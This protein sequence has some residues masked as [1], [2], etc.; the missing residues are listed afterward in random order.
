[1]TTSTHP[2]RRAALAWAG[3]TAGALAALC[4]L[5]GCA[6]AA[7]PRYTISAREL[8]QALAT[9]FP[10]RYPLGGVFEVELQAPA[11]KLLPERNLLNAVMD[12]QAVGLLLQGKAPSGVLDV[13]FGLRYEPS[14]R[15]IRADRLQ[16]NALRLQ[17]LP[18]ALGQNLTRYGVPLAEQALQD[19]V[20]HQLRPKDLALADTLGVQP[21]A[22]RVTPAGL[23]VDLANRPSGR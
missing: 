10:R 18:P 12:L 9:R 23:V 11:L 5:P 16:I 1:M 22:I 20:L 2:T 21:G 6:S 14:D 17:G 7:T 19:V 4:V 13:D 3:S 15:T 8:Q